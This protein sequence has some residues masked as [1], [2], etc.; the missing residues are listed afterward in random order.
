MGVSIQLKQIKPHKLSSR[1]VRA[2]VLNALT[3]EGKSVVGEYNKTIA[4]W[5]GSK[6]RFEYL[7]GYKGGELTV[8]VGPTGDEKGVKKWIWLDEGTKVRWA[9][10]SRDWES[11]TNPGWYGSGPGAG[12]VVIAG[13]RAMMAR[14]I[15]P[16]PGI[17]ARRWTQLI[18][19][20]RKSK[21][22]KAILQAVRAGLE[23]RA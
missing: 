17:E 16:R 13:K 18:A 21:F 6:P 20:R 15:P 12:R 5:R 2:R 22:V 4:T 8:V 9:V 3:A 7:V 1:A 19:K 23:Q 10:M 14:G 11:K